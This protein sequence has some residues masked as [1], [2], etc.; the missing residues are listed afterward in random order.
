MGRQ[1]EARIADKYRAVASGTPQVLPI[2]S[3]RVDGVTCNIKGDGRWE[4][5]S[6]LRWRMVQVIPPA[7]GID[8]VGQ[9]AKH[10]E[11][12]YQAGQRYPVRIEGVDKLVKGSHS[13]YPK[14][15]WR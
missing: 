14:S 11:A 13:R 2:P 15:L 1:L 6:R 10:V 7:R 12:C 9:H 5:E 8:T 4:D 3:Y